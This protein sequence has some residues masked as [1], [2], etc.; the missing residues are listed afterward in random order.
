MAKTSGA[1]FRVARGPRFPC[2]TS[3]G[4]PG[5]QIPVFFGPTGEGLQ[6]HR[7]LARPRALRG[8][9]VNCEWAARASPVFTNVPDTVRDFLRLATTSQRL[10]TIVSVIRC[11]SIDVGRCLR[12]KYAQVC[13]Q[14]VQRV[15]AVFRRVVTCSSGSTPWLPQRRGMREGRTESQANSGSSRGG[16]SSPAVRRSCTAPGE[17]KE[18]GRPHLQQRF[19]T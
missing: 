12:L 6:V 18:A 2:S 11:W 4:T 16:P 10:L 17:P 7:A 14:A 15:L 8:A 1:S 19:G 9:P 5:R 3:D 13:V